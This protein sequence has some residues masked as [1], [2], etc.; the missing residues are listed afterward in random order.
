MKKINDLANNGYKPFVLLILTGFSFNS[1]ATNNVLIW[2]I[3]PVIPA[4]QK[5]SSLW[6][7]NKGDQA[8][9]M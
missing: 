4:D 6:V 5:A 7:E 9:M 8:T 2:P 1:F 3:D